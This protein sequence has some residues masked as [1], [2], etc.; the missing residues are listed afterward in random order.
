MNIQWTK[1]EQ[2]SI[3][4][5]ISKELPYLVRVLGTPVVDLEEGPGSYENKDFT[6]HLS[7]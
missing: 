1:F 6:K 7:L 5:F 4:T 2:K 3:V